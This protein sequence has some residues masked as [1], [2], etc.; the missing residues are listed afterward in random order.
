MSADKPSSGSQAS[1][2]FVDCRRLTMA[3]LKLAIHDLV[4]DPVFDNEDLILKQIQVILSEEAQRRR[5]P[6]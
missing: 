3:P 4:D 5:R 2:H 6:S 1:T